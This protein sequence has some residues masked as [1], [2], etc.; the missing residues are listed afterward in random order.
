MAS[1]SAE[2]NVKDLQLGA[3]LSDSPINKLNTGYSATQ[4][5]CF[6]SGDKHK[7]AD[8]RFRTG[9]FCPQQEAVTSAESYP[10][11]IVREKEDDYSMYHVTGT[12]VNPL[13]V[14]VSIINTSVEM[15]V[16]TGASVSIISE[17]NY[18]HLWSTE[19]APPIQ[20]SNVKLPTYSGEQIYRCQGVN[21]CHCP[22]Q[23]SN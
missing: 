22:E 21:Y 9:Q 23:G 17:A 6:C 18:N 4:K 19:D 15:E 20:E 14:T 8:C 7:A 11:H 10:T 12:P 5:S 16:D 2:K 3:Q 13:L 1:E